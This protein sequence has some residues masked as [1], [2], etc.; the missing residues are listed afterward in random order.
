L[1]RQSILLGG[2]AIHR[3]WA[4]GLSGV[5]T[6]GRSDL[7]A[8]LPLA[9]MCLIH[10]S[11]PGMP[12]SSIMFSSVHDRPAWHRLLALG[13]IWILLSASSW[14][15]ALDH[16]G[17]ATWPCAEFEQAL[18]SDLDEITHPYVPVH[19]IG[20]SSRGMSA[21]VLIVG[22]NG[23]GH[24]LPPERLCAFLPLY[25]LFSNYRI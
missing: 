25:S 15:I 9:T 19:L 17:L 24:D 14:A 11:A 3:R 21:E 23:V 7:T 16:D 13:F 20:E 12:R 22:E 8:G 18:E 6:V 1:L 2:S 5:I 4:D 10:H